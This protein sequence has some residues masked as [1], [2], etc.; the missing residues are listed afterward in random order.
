MIWLSPEKKA[1]FFPSGTFA[2]YLKNLWF[3][4]WIFPGFCKAHV[5]Y[6]QNA[7]Y[8]EDKLWKTF[9]KLMY[10]PLTGEQWFLCA[11]TITKHVEFYILMC[12]TVI[13]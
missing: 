5:W 6:D 4:N 1:R 10:Y 3:K 11:K 12:S 7:I 9:S 2:I 13:S 8:N